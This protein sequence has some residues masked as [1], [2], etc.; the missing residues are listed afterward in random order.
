[1]SIIKQILSLYIHFSSLVSF[2]YF[3]SHIFTLAHFISSHFHTLF[4]LSSVLFFSLLFSSFFGTLQVWTI[5]FG[6]LVSS[7][8]TLTDCTTPRQSLYSF[9]NLILPFFRIFY[10]SLLYSPLLI[11]LFNFS[12]LTFLV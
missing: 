10:D 5:P 7:Y 12:C 6:H 3:T 4:I 2:F 11:C 8:L 1:M 9:S